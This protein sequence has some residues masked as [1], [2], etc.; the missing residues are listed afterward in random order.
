[1][2]TFAI[3][4][5]LAMGVNRME[6]EKAIHDAGSHPETDEQRSLVGWYEKKFRAK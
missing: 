1:M 3:C 2:G 4:L 6:A 5:L